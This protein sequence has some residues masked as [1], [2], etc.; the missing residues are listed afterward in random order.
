M[1][2]RKIIA[3]RATGRA[4]TNASP[5]R[6]LCSKALPPSIELALAYS[7]RALLA[8]NRG[9]D[10]EALEYAGKALAVARQFGDRAAES[11]AL[12]NIGSAQLGRGERIGYETLEQSL[13]LALE[14]NEEYAARTYR[15]TLFYAVLVHDFER[16]D[17]VV[18]RRSCVL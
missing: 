11:H 13:A 7:A 10:K 12:C 6:W 5:P 1:S 15:S 4:P 16:A 18:S 17:R 2:Y 3:P 9:W 8:V 14:H